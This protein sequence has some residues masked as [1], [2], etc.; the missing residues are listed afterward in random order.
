VVATGRL[1]PAVLVHVVCN[2][3][4]IAVVVASVE[5]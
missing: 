2:L 4:G 5:A 1:W 3:T